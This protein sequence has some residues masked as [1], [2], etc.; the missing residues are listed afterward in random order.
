MNK[1]YLMVHEGG[2][3]QQYHG[4]FLPEWYD[5][6]EAGIIDILIFDDDGYRQF[7]GEGFDSVEVVECET[8]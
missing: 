6:F 7:N 3:L 4:E 8:E 1:H 5:A 2:E